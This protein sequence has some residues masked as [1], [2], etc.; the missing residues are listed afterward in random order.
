MGEVKD[1]YEA[2]LNFE[3]PT[4]TFLEVAV[5]DMTDLEYFEA[6]HSIDSVTDSSG[7][8]RFV[9]TG[10]PTLTVG[11]EVLISGFTGSNIPYNTYGIITA[12]VAGDFECATIAWIGTEASGSFDLLVDR[13]RKLVVD[14][15]YKS[16]REE[17]IG[18]A[19]DG[20]RPDA[21]TVIQTTDNTLT[22][23]ATIPITDETTNIIHVDII[24][25]EDDGSNRLGS[26]ISSMFFR[27]GAGSATFIDAGPSGTDDFTVKSAGSWSIPSFAVSG[28]NVLVQVQGAAATT[29]NWVCEANVESFS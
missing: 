24:G 4:R 29:I 21:L 3:F 9:V 23:I 15:C 12:V 2:D 28:N 20:T 6:N 11:R 1:I 26:E 16:I 7:I 25:I 14:E 13:V 19:A 8:A 22:T 5:G 17:L 10:G 27:T 18:F